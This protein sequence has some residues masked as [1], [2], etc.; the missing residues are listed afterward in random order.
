MALTAE[1]QTKK[2]PNDRHWFAYDVL[3][4][5]E[6]IVADS[7]DPE[8]ELA[9]ALLARGHHGHVTLIDSKTGKPRTHINIEKAAKW[10]VGRNLERYK[11]KGEQRSDYSPPAGESEAA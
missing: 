8:H 6:I 2:K 5:G 9:R 3:F 10:C 7:R 11:W 1:L 4:D